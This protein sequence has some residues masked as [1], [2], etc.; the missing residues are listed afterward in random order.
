MHRRNFIFT[1]AAAVQNLPQAVEAVANRVVGTD[2]LAAGLLR[3]IIGKTTQ[4]KILGDSFCDL[5]DVKNYSQKTGGYSAA[6]FLAQTSGSLDNLFSSLLTPYANALPPLNKADADR[7][8]GLLEEHN[9]LVNL[10][11]T[12]EK[13]NTLEKDELNRTPLAQLIENTKKSL[14]R[15]NITLGLKGDEASSF[16]GSNSFLSAVKTGDIDGYIKTKLPFSLNEAIQ[17]AL[18]KGLTNSTKNPEFRGDLVETLLRFLVEGTKKK[19]FLP[20]QA[21]KALST[22]RALVTT[23]ENKF[24]L[25]YNEVLGL[26]DALPSELERVALE[27]AANNV[28]PGETEKPDPNKTQ[29]MKPEPPK[30]P[31]VKQA[32]RAHAERVKAARTEEEYP[33]LPG[34]PS[35]RRAPRSSSL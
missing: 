25:H 6:E 7:I 4:N 28:K 3:A 32:E 18:V 23:E 21:T 14:Q 24:G 30:Q 11:S 9:R 20:D 16:I 29:E 33:I 12:Y 13:A 27:T 2:R 34:T 26:I 22:I 1:S 35:G 8:H 17:M 5:G 31:E 15:S 19:W 10:L